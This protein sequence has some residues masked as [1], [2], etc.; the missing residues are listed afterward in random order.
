MKE[1]R[2]SYRDI[3]KA[4]SLF[5][6]VQVFNILI[7]IVRSKIIAIL[8]GPAGMGIAG[9][10]T[11][12]T[13]LVSA[14]TNF[15]LGTSAVRNV[16]EANE[17]GDKTRI[18]KVI[19]IFR[20]LVW[21]TGIL[22][23]VTTIT[24]SSWLSE[25]VF[26]NKDYTVAFIWLSITLLFTQL[27]SG[28][29][30]LL[31]GMR[32]L[33]YLAKANLLGSLL[34]LIVSVPIYYYYRIDGIVP[35]LIITSILSFA[36]ARFFTK[37][38]NIKNVSVTRYEA[39]SEGKNMLNMGIMLSLSS[40]LTLGASFVLRIFISKTGGVEDVGL[41]T[42]GVAIIATYAG[43]VLT[44]MSKDYYPRLS[45]VAND[46][47]K[48]NLLINQQMDI[49][50]LILAPILAIFIIFINWIVILLYSTKFIP[51]NS[52]IQWAAIGMYF[53]VTSWCLGYL[54]LAKGATKVFFW[55]E[56]STNLY[57]LGLNIAGYK[58][59]GIEGLG[60]SYVVGYMFYFLQIYFV[61]H[62]KYKFSFNS[63]FY[64][65][66]GIQLAIGII[67]LLVVKVIPKPWFYLLGIPLIALSTYYSFKELD[68]R[69][70]LKSLVIGYL[71]K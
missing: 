8:L 39:R 46:I 47:G 71:K 22:G 10:L 64:K 13:G 6:G 49:G 29:N 60:I 42:A 1:N 21:I 20:R 54:L 59:L 19:T 34:S 57:V 56:L 53:K 66:F 27:T 61:I 40:L 15:G 51:M 9:L 11:S 48:S 30:V 44:A 18:A 63:N 55:T 28:Q 14:M 67:S 31:Q 68:K 43:L 50:I 69:I 62:Y 65:I 23:T 37:K 24:L 32:K 45:G 7:S 12:T 5:G 33:K 2:S 26:G 3:F 70:G 38:I 41:Y 17:S 4:T 16:A 52:M 25:I 35:A 36:I 58:F